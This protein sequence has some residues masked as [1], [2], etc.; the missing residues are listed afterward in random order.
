MSIP[1]KFVNKVHDIEQKLDRAIHDDTKQKEFQKL[2]QEKKNVSLYLYRNGYFILRPS[3]LKDDKELLN[4]RKEALKRRYKA[5]KIYRISENWSKL[6]CY[7]TWLPKCKRLV[8][9]F[10]CCKDKIKA[11][12][13]FALLTNYYSRLSDIYM[14][15]PIPGIGYRYYSGEKVIIYT[16]HEKMT[17]KQVHD[18]RKA[19]YSTTANGYPIDNCYK[20]V[21]STT[22]NTFKGYDR[23][24][25]VFNI[26]DNMAFI[27]QFISAWKGKDYTIVDLKNYC[28][29]RDFK[30]C[31][32]AI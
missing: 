9:D 25:I 29:F 23:D 4:E 2:C 3:N 21:L 27:P 24:W 6:R 20:I 18:F 12:N 28:K 26:Y 11:I 19:I 13:V 22:T 8:I 17:T 1:V 16:E 7:R 15:S 5:L 30:P 14:Y 10:T 32:V 31:F